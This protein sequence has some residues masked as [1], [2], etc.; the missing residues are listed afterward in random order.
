MRSPPEHGAGLAEAAEAV[1]RDQ[2]L[3]IT[4]ERD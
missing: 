1:E 3:G 2:Q 4:V